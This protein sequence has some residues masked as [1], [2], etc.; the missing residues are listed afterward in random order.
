[1]MVEHPLAVKAKAM[2]EPWR[3]HFPKSPAEANVFTPIVRRR[4]LAGRVLA[5]ARTRIECR[6]SAYV[7]AV[8]GQNH[9]DEVAGVL[10]RGAKLD[11]PVARALFPEFAEVEYC[12]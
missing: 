10:D 9:A 11:E 3:S 6:W 1:M 8:D 2:P 12:E 7:D 4:A 5:V